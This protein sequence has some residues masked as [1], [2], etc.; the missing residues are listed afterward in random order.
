MPTDV[1]TPVRD[2]AKRYP[3]I[4]GVIFADLDGQQISVYPDGAA[5]TLRHCAIFS[6]IALRR[7]T[8]AERLAGRGVVREVNL[9]GTSGALLAM[10][11]SDENQLVVTLGPNARL[12]EVSAATRRAAKSLEVAST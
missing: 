6:G 3:Q 9:E 1:S 5:E 2:L 11:V 10:M 12:G 4:Q 7:L 8:V